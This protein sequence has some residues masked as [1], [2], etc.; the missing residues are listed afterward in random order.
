MKIKAIVNYS[1][2]FTLTI[3]Y[4]VRSWDITYC[5]SRLIGQHYHLYMIE[6]IY[7]RKIVG[8]EVHDKENGDNAAILVECSVWA[9]RFVK[10]QLVYIQTMV[11]NEKYHVKNKMQELGVVSFY[12]SSRVRNYNPNSESL[13]RT[14]KYYPWSRCEGFSNLADPRLWV[15]NLYNCINMTMP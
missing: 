11:P 10:N 8:W 4:I 13:F 7:S 12:S 6:D 5:T 9:E 1:H 3:P 2:H 15:K 14:V